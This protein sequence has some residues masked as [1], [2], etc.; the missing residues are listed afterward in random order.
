MYVTFCLTEKKK[1]R[2]MTLAQCERNRWQ[3][4]LTMQWFCCCSKVGTSPPMG[5]CLASSSSFAQIHRHSSSRRPRRRDQ[6]SALASKWALPTHNNHFNLYT[7]L[8]LYLVFYLLLSEC[9]LEEIIYWSS[10]YLCPLTREHF[11]LYLVYRSGSSFP[12][13]QSLSSWKCCL[14]AW[15]EQFLSCFCSYT[16]I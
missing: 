14:K 16:F 1:K 11:G 3:Q 12:F 6:R 5:I 9:R 15:S 2:M 8:S 7:S 10:V 4:W 13:S